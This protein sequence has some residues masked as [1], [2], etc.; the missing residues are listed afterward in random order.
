MERQKATMP[1][2]I[3]PWG[4]LLAYLNQY[5]LRRITCKTVHAQIPLALY[6]IL[7]PEKRQMLDRAANVLYI[8]NAYANSACVVY[9]SRCVNGRE[10]NVISIEMP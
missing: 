4:Y 2:C 1:I 10:A 6:N 5:Y 8:K 9:I 3:P 7:L